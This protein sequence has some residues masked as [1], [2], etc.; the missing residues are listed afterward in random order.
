MNTWKNFTK[1]ELSCSCC[2]EENPNLE[3]IEL[4]DLVQDMRD[5]LGFPLPV[6]SAYRCSEHPIE[7]KKK[8]PGM[9]NVAAI[10]IKVS[11]EKAHK[12]LKKAMEMGF[13]GIGVN[14][15]GNVNQ[16]FI[17]LDLREEGRIWSY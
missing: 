5:E 14:Q 9:H 4:M 3:F 12:V 1:N 6:S 2:G 7:A 10:D 16:R 13:T 11:H 8:T 15:T 17:H